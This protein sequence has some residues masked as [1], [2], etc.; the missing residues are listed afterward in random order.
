MNHGAPANCTDCKGRTPMHKA[1]KVG[2]H[3]DI[4]ELKEKGGAN[5]NQQDNKGKTALHD[6]KDY[7]TVVQL[8]KYGADPQKKAA[9]TKQGDNISA[10]EYLM[11]RNRQDECPDAILDTYIDLKKNSD[12]I[13]DFAIFKDKD[14]SKRPEEEAMDMSFLETCSVVVDSDVS[15]E[16]MNHP[17]LQTFFKLKV[18]TVWPILTFFTVF[19]HLAI[20]PITMTTAGVVYSFH[21]SCTNITDILNAV[22]VGERHC[23]RTNF[24]WWGNWEIQFCHNEPNSKD[25]MFSYRY[26]PNTQTLDKAKKLLFNCKNG[27][28][29]FISSDIATGEL[30][31][32]RVWDSSYLYY[33]TVFILATYVLKEMLELLVL[34][35]Q[36]FKYF[37]NLYAWLFIFIASAFVITSN[38]IP[39]YASK[40]VGWLVF[41]VW[42]EV[43][44]YI[45]T[46]NIYYSL[47]DYAYM[48]IQVAKPAL[49]CLIAH[50][51]IFLAFTFGFDI[52][53]R[54]NP[55]YDMNQGNG[56]LGA[57]A[58]VMSM[59]LEPT[60]EVNFSYD[61][62][63]K[64]GGHL[65][66]SQFM[67]L[68]FI[69]MVPIIVVNM[70]IAVSVS[71]TDLKGM[72]EMSRLMRVKRNINELKN[73]AYWGRMKLCGM[74]PFKTIL[75]PLETR[76]ILY[77]LDKY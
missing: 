22:D 23:F 42:F 56:F 58:K 29:Q 72:K 70:L 68:L 57:F 48:S 45:G 13:M 32:V 55:M 37:E 24:E 75:K 36:Y 28:I 71:Q 53:L 11:R 64:N 54:N 20:V 49:L 17:L 69:V 9:K 5:V 74:K 14:P 8:L 40:F 15:Y 19:Y 43:F 63:E 73:F 65:K 60:Y 33:W 2:A 25:A 26:H 61:V 47:G 1:A 50:M 41:I 21:F 66:S 38:F 39:I 46:C 52:M 62:L 30:P 44:F 6:A 10:L 16:V 3:I 12:L 34:K 31:I 27:A 7:K 18:H 67:G 4:A 59:M 77:F 76:V 51:P 35:S